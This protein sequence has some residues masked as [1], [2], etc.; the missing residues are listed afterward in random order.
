MI[1]NFDHTTLLVHDVEAGTDAYRQILGREPT[2]RIQAEG[3]E[4]VLF[5]LDNAMLRIASPSGAG[6]FGDV[7]RAHLD[8]FGEGLSGLVFRVDDIGRTYRRLR[9]LSLQPEEVSD[10]VEQYPA[11]GLTY[12]WK[13]TELPSRFSH[14]IPISFGNPAT[15]MP[16]SKASQS[17]VRRMDLLVVATQDAERATILYGARLGLPLSFD[18]VNDQNNSRL[19]QFPCGDMLIEVVHRPEEGPAK[20]DR[21]QGIGWSVT[22][23][24]SARTRLLRA[25]RNVS[26]VKVGAKPNTRVFTVRDGTCNIPTLVIEHSPTLFDEA[27]GGRQKAIN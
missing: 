2:F 27:A 15:E 26:D 4:S 13:R 16:I 21:L 17:S 3:L 25:G 7:A 6:I 19:M 1:V 24:D 12:R 18:H 10:V 11:R 22:D 5:V 14:G 23:A 9:R 20:L 8:K